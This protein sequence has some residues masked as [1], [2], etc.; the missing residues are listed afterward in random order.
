MVFIGSKEVHIYSTQSGV[1]HFPK[2]STT[3]GI[4]VE[5]DYTW[6]DLATE[7]VQTLGMIDSFA[8]AGLAFAPIM[9]L[10]ENPLFHTRF[11]RIMVELS[12]PARKR[13]SEAIMARRIQIK[14][15]KMHVMR[16]VPLWWMML[17]RDFYTL[18]Q[19]SLP[20]PQQEEATQPQCP[21]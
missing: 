15:Q 10:Y 2:M 19:Q 12:A 16:G 5:C 9:D 6:E 11:G 8:L 21:K 7:T 13:Y 18:V 1:F 14:L 3:A 20:P 17:D 4:K